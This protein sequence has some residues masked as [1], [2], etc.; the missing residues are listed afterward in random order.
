M[1]HDCV[2]L[3]SSAV[4]GTLYTTQRLHSGCTFDS[5]SWLLPGILLALL[6]RCP[7]KLRLAG[8]CHCICEG[9]TVTWYWPNSQTRKHVD[10]GTFHSCIS[11]PKPASIIWNICRLWNFHSSSQTVNCSIH[12]LWIHI[13]RLQQLSYREYPALGY[14]SLWSS[15]YSRNFYTGSSCPISIQK[16]NTPNFRV[17]SKQGHTHFS[18]QNQLTLFGISNA[19]I[20]DCQG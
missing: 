11:S 20:Q 9:I 14:I 3:D 2:G 18:C 7:R 6:G 19:S 15:F 10:K 1:T 17:N 12:T 8:H 13:D 5:R 4:S 16:I